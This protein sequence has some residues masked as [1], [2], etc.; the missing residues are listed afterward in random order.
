MDVTI[1]P[2][3]IADAA[4]I[5]QV[6]V[7]SWRTTY[8][9]IVPQAYLDSLDVTARTHSWSEQILAAGSI[10]LVAQDVDGL[11]GFICGGALREPI[12]GYD[13]ELYAIYLLR[14]CQGQGTGRRLTIALSDSLRAA[15]FRAMVVWVLE[16]N[17]AVG[18]YMRLG[19]THLARKQLEI[20]GAMLDEI[21]LGWPSLD[22]SFIA[23]EN[24]S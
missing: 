23:V 3:T 11:V 16:R 22:A 20:G 10:F 5:A 2:A 8:A 17:P 6:H 4:A 7:A 13:T 24:A 12:P 21:A 15:G 9:G 1:R 19:A 18:F 14:S